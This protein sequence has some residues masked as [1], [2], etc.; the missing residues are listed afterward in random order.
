MILAESFLH[1]ITTSHY[2]ILAGVLFAIG[3]IGV[4]TRRNA[5]IVLMSLE[6]MMNAAN[7][8]F[9]AFSRVHQ[10][11][12]P[13]HW[14][15]HVFVFFVMTVA[16]AEA[17]VALAIIIALFRQKESVDVESVDAMRG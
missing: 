11:V 15:G 5:I 3:L 13:T 4:I 8:L 16:A 9:V 6:L 7:V 1:P 14:D 12:D 17:A 2:V 10:Q